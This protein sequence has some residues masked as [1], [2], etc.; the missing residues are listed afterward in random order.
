MRREAFG[1]MEE[2]H[3]RNIH[4]ATEVSDGFV[5]AAMSTAGLAPLVGG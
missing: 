2:R 4:P 1:W 3:A 5:F